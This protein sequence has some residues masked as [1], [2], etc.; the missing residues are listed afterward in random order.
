MFLQ[1]PISQLGSIEVTGNCKTFDDSAYGYCRGKA[2]GTVILKSLDDTIADN[3][4]VLGRNL[5]QG[6]VDLYDVSSVEM[7]GTGTQVGDVGEMSSVLD[8]VAPPLEVV[9]NGRSSAEPL[10]LGSAKANI[11]HG[12]AASGVSSLITVLLMMQK[13]TIV[14]YCGIN[15]DFQPIY[16]NEIAAGG[17]SAVL[18]EDAPLKRE[19]PAGTTDPRSHHLV[20]FSAKN[21]VSLQGNLRSMLRYLKQNPALFPLASFLHHHSAALHHLHRVML[22]GSSAEEVSTQIET[23]LR[24]I[25]GMTKPKSTPKVVFTCTGKGAQYPGM[26]KEL[27]GHFSLFRTEICRLDQLGQNLGFPSILPVI[28]STEQDIGIFAPIVVQLASVCLQIALGNYGHLGI[29]SLPPLSDIV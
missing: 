9:K 25:T 27:V 19:F 8:T 17:N 7:H 10:Y 13:N 16:K 23:A 26:G 22:T 29:L 4:P 15:V 6:A 28:Q 2:I 21:G 5:N 18:L 14:P 20:A 3:D 1:T 12:E 11:G 24:D